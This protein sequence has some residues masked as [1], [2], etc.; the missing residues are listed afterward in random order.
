MPMKKILE[1]EI[2]VRYKVKKASAGLGLFATEN[3]KKGEKII[4]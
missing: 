4:E 1:T 2:P 3:I